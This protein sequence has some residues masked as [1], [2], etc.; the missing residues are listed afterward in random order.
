MSAS[1]NSGGYGCKL[2]NTPPKELQTECSICLELLRDPEM[3]NCCG[4]KFC[5]TCIRPVLN[6]KKPCPLCGQ[7][8]IS[9]MADRQ[10]QRTLNDL[11]VYCQHAEDGCKW[12]G[13][14]GGV[15]GHLNGEYT[16]ENRLEGCG[17]VQVECPECGDVCPRKDGRSHMEEECPEAQLSCKFHHIGCREVLS[18]KDMQQHVQSNKSSHMTLLLDHTQKL[19]D[20][21]NRKSNEILNV[22]DNLGDKEDG[23][24]LSNEVARAKKRSARVKVRPKPVHRSAMWG[25]GGGFFMA[26]LL[27]ALLAMNMTENP[28][29]GKRRSTECPEELKQ[30]LQDLEQR[31][32]SISQR[33]IP[34]TIGD[35][36]NEVATRRAELEDMMQEIRGER[37]RQQELGDQFA[38]KIAESIKIRDEMLKLQ[39]DTE[40]NI[41][42]LQDETIAQDD[43]GQDY[44]SDISD[45][46]A[47]L[48]GVLGDLVE[49]KSKMSG[50]SN[51]GDVE[52]LG[53]EL[54]GIRDDLQVTK[55][56][57]EALPG[58]SILLL[59][60]QKLVQEELDKMPPPPPHGRHRGHGRHHG[61]G[62]HG[63]R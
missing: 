52:G 26:A 1:E 13:K 47:R 45:L 53:L 43:K 38:E 6:R 3:V 48:T 51:K 19:A 55:Q 44:S 46:K 7:R 14:L 34:G 50:F 21:Y 15:A 33:S 60:L 32:E 36:S 25:I 11:Q 58:L 18:R 37:A 12:E 40:K 61:H 29:Q 54:S 62:C 31:L 56:R 27:A 16:P 8:N 59:E 28:L 23:L 42:K 20:E 5:R 39:E 49:L 63:H 35:D 17:H 57:V 22:I 9:T 41:K 2:V 4:Y 30:G 24:T 10:L